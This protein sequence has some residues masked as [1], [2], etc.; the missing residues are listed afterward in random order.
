MTKKGARRKARLKSIIQRTDDGERR[1]RNANGY[2][3]HLID[4][5]GDDDGRIQNKKREFTTR[6]RT[7]KN[8]TR[9]QKT[10][11][12]HG[13]DDVLLFIIRVVVHLLFSFTRSFAFSHSLSH[14]H[15]VPLSLPHPLPLIHTLSV[16]H[17]IRVLIKERELTVDRHQQR[18]G[19]TTVRGYVVRPSLEH[20]THGYRLPYYLNSCV[21]RTCMV[22]VVYALCA[23]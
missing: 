4:G 15:S 9:A 23:C 6:P 2:Y 12:P 16:G 19:V 7:Y 20:R 11:H 18:R 22:Y 8:P 1:A 13:N 3:I 14:T 21:S 17:G 10:I 5:G